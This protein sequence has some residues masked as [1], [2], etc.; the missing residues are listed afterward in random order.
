MMMKRSIHSLGRW[1]GLAAVGAALLCAL[2]GH[3]P[4][5]AQGPAPASQAHFDSDIAPI[6]AK[7]C[8]GCHSG[9]Q[10][11]GDI[12]LRFKDEAEARGKAANDEFWDKVATEVESGRM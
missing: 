11:K 7:N 6:F 9:A 1:A 5:L 2:A 3:E 10:P 12:L 8:V 4:L